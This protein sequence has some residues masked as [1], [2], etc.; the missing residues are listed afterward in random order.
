MIQPFP[1]FWNTS[2]VTNCV[3]FPFGRGVCNA[4]IITVWAIEIP[5]LTHHDIMVDIE[6][7]VLT[8]SCNLKFSLTTSL[9]VVNTHK[10]QSSAAITRFWGPRNRSPYSGHRVIAAGSAM[11]A[12]WLVFKQRGS[13]AILG[14]LSLSDKCGPKPLQFI[15]DT[16]IYS[17]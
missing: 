15:T 16:T 9:F 14:N 10:I 5:S 1:E 2:D 7:M 8:G 4:L 13:W 6:K 17:C 12:F 11:D 3:D